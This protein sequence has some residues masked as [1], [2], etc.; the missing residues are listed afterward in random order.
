M[1]SLLLLALFV[2]LVASSV[3]AQMSRGVSN[4]ELTNRAAPFEKLQNDIGSAVA[5][6]PRL[7]EVDRAKLGHANLVLGQAISDR[8][9]QH[10]VNKK[11][12]LAALKD[13]EALESSG[14]FPD[15]DR[16]VLASDRK[17]V[18]AAAKE[19][20]SVRFVYTGKAGQPI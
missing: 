4:E 11:K 20:T 2:S 1:R 7:T 10:K 12:V 14:V 5:H 15:P 17:R 18:E 9:D 19:P 16:K 8:R 13:L 6:A 3:R